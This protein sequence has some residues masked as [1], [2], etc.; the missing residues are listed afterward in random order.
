MGISDLW[1]KEQGDRDLDLTEPLHQGHLESGSD[2]MGKL[3]G[4]KYVIED[5]LGYG[6]MGVLYTARH[7]MLG[8]KYVIKIIRLHLMDKHAQVAVKRFRREAQALAKVLHPNVVEVV[9]YDLIDEQTPY[10]VMEFVEGKN[11]SQL[12]ETEANGL[13]VDL[14]L[15]IMEQ[16]C[17]ALDEVHSKGIIHRDL[18]PSNLMVQ[19]RD[20]EILVKLLDFGL[21]QINSSEFESSIIKLTG[22]G[23]VIGTPAYMAPEQCRGEEIDHLSDVYALGLLAHEMLTGM[24]AMDGETFVEV[25]E[26]QLNENPIPVNQIKPEVPAHIAL[27]IQKAVAKNPADRFQKASDFLRALKGELQVELKPEAP[28]APAPASTKPPWLWVIVGVILVAITFW[29]VASWPS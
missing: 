11:L 6:G 4:G 14:F 16:V 9:D 17:H 12:L 20:G 5:V 15:V 18:K 28:A 29:L 27:A 8:R 25:V 3:V 13:P 21:V 7:K 2:M 24:P 10:F 23:Q 22:T 1:K 19:E 26:R